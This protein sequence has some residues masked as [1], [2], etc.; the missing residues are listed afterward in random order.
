MAKEAADFLNFNPASPTGDPRLDAYLGVQPSAEEEPDLSQYMPAPTA[1]RRTKA[2][3]KEVPL[4]ARALLDTIASKESPDYN[5][6]YGGQKFSDYSDHPG[7]GVTIKGGPNAGKTASAAGRYQL[8]RPTWEDQRDKLGL[9]DFS[10]ENQDKAAWNL[11]QETYNSRTSRNLLEDIKSGNPAVQARIGNVLSKVWTSLPGGIEQGQG[12]TG[13]IGSL[14]Q[15]L[16]IH[17][18]MDPSAY[19]ASLQQQQGTKEAPQEEQAPDLSNTYAIP[20]SNGQTLHVPNGTDR[21]EAIRHIQSQGIEAEGLRPI[22]LADGRTLHVP[23]SV[24]DLDALAKVKEANPDMDF[25]TMHESKTGFVPAVKS[26]FTSAGAQTLRGLGEMGQGAGETLGIAP[27]QHLGE[28]GIQKSKELE[29]KTKGMAETPTEQDPFLTRNITHPLGSVVGGVA[30]YVAGAAIAPEAVAP[31]LMGSTMFGQAMGSLA[32]RAD[33]QGKDFEALKATPAAAAETAVNYVTNVFGPLRPFFK[34]NFVSQLAAPEAGKLINE[35][36]EKVGLEKTR[37]LVGSK[38]SNMVESA[39]INIGSMA[40]GDTASS[41]IERAQ[42]G[43]DLASEDAVNEYMSNLKN[44]VVG[45]L[46]FGGVQGPGRRAEKAGALEQAEAGMR[47]AAPK[48]AA[49]TTGQMEEAKA[50]TE[51]RIAEE[52]RRANMTPPSE[53]WVDELGLTKASGAYKQLKQLDVNDTD[54]HDDIKRI[55]E[56]VGSRPHQKQDTKAIQNLYDYMDTL[57][58]EEANK[59]K[60]EFGDVFGSDVQKFTDRLGRASA[61]LTAPKNEDLKTAVDSAHV[62]SVLDTLMQSK[63]PALRWIA[64]KAK[65]LPDLTIR[66]D[67]AAIKKM[68]TSLSLGK[69][70]QLNG[71]YHSGTGEVVMRPSMASDERVVGHELLHGVTVRTMNNLESKI[72]TGA[73]LTR[74]EKKL[75]PA[76]NGLAKLHDAVKDHPTL[77]GQYGLTNL[78]EFVAEGLANPEF[79]YKLSRIKYEN[80]TMWGKFTQSLANLLRLKNDNAFTELVTHTETLADKPTKA[81]NIT[82][83]ITAT[84]EVGGNKGKFDITKPEI[85]AHIGEVENPREKMH[86]KDVTKRTPELQEAANKL[87]AGDITAE[88]YDKLVNEYKP[89]TPYKS[90]PKP[91]TV[92]EMQKA[93][94][95]DKV[96]KIGNAATVL[97]EGDKVGLRLDIPA[98]RDHGTWVVSIHNPRTASGAGSPVGYNSVA[99][100][101]NVKFGIHEK[102]GLNIAAGKGKATIATMEGGWKPTTPQAAESRA[103]KL[104]NDPEWVQVGMDPERHSYFYDRKNMKPVTEA[105]EVLQIGGLVLAKNP[106]YASKSEFLYDIGEKSADQIQKAAEPN[107]GRRPQPEVREEGEGAPEGGERVREGRPEGGEAEEGKRLTEDDPNAN[108]LLNRGIVKTSDVDPKSTIKQITDWF[109]RS[110]TDMATRIRAALVTRYAPWTKALENKEFVDAEGKLRA[111]L[112]GSAYQQIYNVTRTGHAEG[113][114]VMGADGTVVIQESHLA[115]Q[116]IQKRIDALDFNNPRH[117]VASVLRVLRGEELLNDPET[118]DKEKVVTQEAIDEAHALLRDHPELSQV[119]SDVHDLNAHLL[120]LLENS[121]LVSKE[122]ADVWRK[123]KN[124][125]PLYKSMEDIVTDPSRHHLFGGTKSVAEIKKLMGSEQQVNVLENMIRHYTFA[126]MGAAQNIL[127]KNA[128]EQLEHV[129]AM[130]KITEAEAAN[131]PLAVMFKEDG[132]KVFYEAHDP[133][134]FEAFQAAQPLVHPFFTKFTKPMTKV[135]RA[136]TLVN[137]VFWYKQLV[138]DSLHATLSADVGIIT[139]LNAATQMLKIL[140]GKSE[141]YKKLTRAGVVGAVDALNDPRTF[142][143]AFARKPSKWHTMSEKIMK[144][145]ESADAA[146]RVAVYE[147]VYARAIKDGKTPAQAETLATMRAREIIN[148]SNQGKSQ[149]IQVIRASV[150]F[151]SAAINS[152]DVVAR[153]A[154]GVGIPAHERAAAKRLFYTRVASLAAL[155]AGYA[156]AMQDDEDYKKLRNSNDW[157]MNWLIPTGNKDAPF[158]K[159][160]VP[161]ELGLFTKVLPELWVR[162][163]SGTITKREAKATVL[164]TVGQSLPPMPLPLVFKTPLEAWMNYNTFTGR[165]IEGPGE[166]NLPV[167]ERGKNASEIAKAIGHTLNLSPAKIDHVGRGLLTELWG[168]TSILADAYLN[169]D[170]VTPEKHIAEY[171]L[172]HGLVTRPDTERMVN[173]FF[174]LETE[175]RQMHQAIQGKLT[176]GR[177]AEFKEDMADPEKAKLYRGAAPLRHISDNMSKLRKAMERVKNDQKLSKEQMTAEL[178]R[179]NKSYNNMAINGYQIAKKLGIE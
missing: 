168:T 175:A 79:Q 60:E 19:A 37:E 87:K 152:L 75:L 48:P 62:P 167:S 14:N 117:V 82:P 85:D 126:T 83:S 30:P 42:S 21:A 149:A 130:T 156:I 147:S 107:A 141:T 102:A 44:D 50:A 114:P 38:L 176:S 171:P 151:F 124:Y 63:N 40:L 88:D 136:A 3:S 129:G 73:N 41:I 159:V 148:F 99:S 69:N 55:L 77:N 28:A 137:P 89:T 170:K 108:S 119:V 36:L 49:P 52:E 6:I 5:T 144:V 53:N 127:R 10:P 131:N 15:N 103:K 71:Y 57:S 92:G 155:S 68:E 177:L 98:Y 51:T 67:G 169:K 1:G 72:T 81:K 157:A 164:Q 22:A 11:A 16:D 178:D 25:T 23:E 154:T 115:P 162:L 128:T 142:S 33:E 100:A 66:S 174:E 97:K 20:L 95:S 104:L 90:I 134:M 113:I 58:P 118:A 150:P 7:V 29:E 13:F 12:M 17:R 105:D 106:K 146:T 163:N 78:K 39:G 120:N 139:P 173:N 24:S 116:K 138:R 45:G 160:P 32:E 101:T 132:K 56:E 96:D 166:A 70:R 165:P 172:M 2:A 143:E 153:A 54:H 111:D 80:T 161:F 94:T 112:Q 34:N 93:L 74:D 8:I 35:S 133:V 9:K 110:K 61:K 135:F 64:E 86:Y 27:L 84:A 76:Y 179:L 31:A 59:R 65:D 109:N 91:A 140:R 26:A 125:I 121:G 18:G 158:F 4:E 122:A 43:Q 123:N 145:H 47:A 46:F